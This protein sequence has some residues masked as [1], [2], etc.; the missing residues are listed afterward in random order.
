MVSRR[1]TGRRGRRVAKRSLN[2]GVRTML[3]KLALTL[4]MATVL[5]VG[6]TAATIEPAHAGG[7]GVATGIAA[8]IVTLGVLGA[9]SSAH[10]DGYRERVYG[11]SCYYGPRECYRRERCYINDFGDRICRQGEMVCSRRRVCD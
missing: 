7:R 11:E 6:S 5:A 4:S 2:S 10:A 1:P 3:K 8:G 9:L